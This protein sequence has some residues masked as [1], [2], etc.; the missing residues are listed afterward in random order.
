MIGVPC[1]VE[2]A[3][4]LDVIEPFTGGV[5]QCV[6]CPGC[7]VQLIVRRIP[8]GWHVRTMADFKQQRTAPLPAIAPKSAFRLGG[9]IKRM[10]VGSQPGGFVEPGDSSLRDEAP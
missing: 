8:E 9:F 3:F 2:C 10:F 5:G 4:R 7:G 6:R 1:C